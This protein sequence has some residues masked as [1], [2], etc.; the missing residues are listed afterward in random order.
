MLLFP[1]GAFSEE[2]LERKLRCS[3]PGATQADASEILSELD[4]MPIHGANEEAAPG[5]RRRA[6]IDSIRLGN[7]DLDALRAAVREGMRD[8]RD[9]QML[10]EAPHFRGF[11]SEGAAFAEVNQRDLEEFIAWLQE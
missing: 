8:Y 4:R 2:N 6:K 7:G 1:D 11:S 5:F 9:L 10:A 3:F